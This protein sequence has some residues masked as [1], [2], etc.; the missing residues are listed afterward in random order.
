MSARPVLLRQI[1]GS[2]SCEHVM[3]VGAGQDEKEEST[4]DKNRRV[5]NGCIKYLCAF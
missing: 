4:N 1:S 3:G 5:L 2:M